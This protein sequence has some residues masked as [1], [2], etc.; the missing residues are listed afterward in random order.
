MATTSA[1]IKSALHK[2]LAEGVYRDLITRNSNYYYFLGRTLSWDD[3][4]LPESPVDNY[5]Y[6]RLVRSE[7]ITFKEIRASDVSFVVPR[8]NWSANTIFDMYDD[9][10]GDQVIG[11]DIVSGGSGYSSL[12][13]ITISGG[14]GTGAVYTPVIDT[15][16]GQLIGVD[17]VS[18]GYGYQS[19]PT[20][21]ITGGRATGIGSDAVLRAVMSFAYNGSHTLEDSMFYVVTDEFNVYKC[22]ENN[23]N[24]PSTVK[25]TG[26]QITPILTADGYVWKYMYNVPI[27]LRNKFLSDDQIPVVSALSNQFFSGGAIDTVII[28]NKGSGYTTANIVVSGDGSLEADPVLITDLV[29]GVGGSGYTNP[30]VT[31]SPPVLGATE[32]LAS[33]AVSLDQNI[34][35]TNGDYYN[36]VTPGTLGSLAPTHRFGTVANGT[37]ALKY[38]G[39]RLTAEATVVDG[40]ITEVV[41]DGSVLDVQVVSAGSGYI[42]APTVNITPAVGDTTG[43]GAVAITKMNNDSVLYVTVTNSGDFY[44]ITPDVTFGEQWT[45]GDTVLVNEQYYY[46]SRLY[47][48]TVGGTF[49]SSPPSHTTGSASN[50]TAT[51]A[52]AGSPATGSVSRRFGAGYNTVPTIVVSDITGVDAEIEVRLTASSAKLLPILDNGQMVGVTIVDAGIGY[53]T[54]SIEVTGDGEGCVLVPDLTLGNIQSLQANNELLTPAG[55]L[56][57]IKVVSGGYGYGVANI[58]ITG[59]GTGATATASIN[60]ASGRVDKITIVTPGT[61]YTF[62]NIEIDGNGI[63]ATARGIIAPYGGHGK[64][65]PDELFARTLMFYSNVSTDLNQGVSVNNDYRQIGLIKNPRKYSDALK[66]T[67]TLG[68]ACFILGVNIDAEKVAL[69]T[70]GDKETQFMKDSELTVPRTI[71]GIVYLRRYRIVNLSTTYVLLQSLND[72]VPQ[73][74]DTFT[75]VSGAVIPPSFQSLTVGYPTVDKYS[76]QLMFIDNKAGFTPSADETVTLRTVLRF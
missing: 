6:E 39:T 67:E 26:T 56:N 13:T 68:S 30:T 45:S 24:A 72:D 73:A 58:L 40:V 36:V 70:A 20:V 4:T 52:Y 2:A 57:A 16:S 62:A 46:E 53:T 33:G 10:Y 37:A 74:N 75:L 23:N 60:G 54:A 51:L 43:S 69:T 55:T 15:G 21:T 1:L 17:L 7:I 14:G 42:S 25:P 63:G 5:E 41:M 27:N 22:L 49:S 34:V 3:E 9:T 8:Y 11:I 48:V 65:A 38:K 66:F 12:P 31:V 32:F 19:V 50:G 44:S 28:N 47:T 61:G 35:T 18:K 29:V 76:G 71:D 59:D 64:N